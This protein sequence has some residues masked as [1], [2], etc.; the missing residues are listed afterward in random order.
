MTREAR[1]LA[2]F[3]GLL[4][5]GELLYLLVV[6]D[7]P[8]YTAYLEL[9]AEVT[10]RILVLCG[11]EVLREGTRLVSE[12]CWF[13]VVRGCDGIQ[14]LLLYGTA[15]LA[16]PGVRRTKAIALVSGLL[17]VLGLNFVRLAS[18]FL[19]LAHARPSYDTVH[20]NV[21]PPVLILCVLSMWGF[22]ALRSTR[23]AGEAS[24]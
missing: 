10:R 1:F 6:V 20:L 21:W 9:N 11:Y 12:G 24:G 3:G 15:V 23:A 22:W 14:L 2:L 13:E 18:L 16:F 5:G 4:L 17:A 7:S 19:T 8:G